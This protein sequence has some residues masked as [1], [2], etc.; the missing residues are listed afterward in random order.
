MRVVPLG[1][2]IAVKRLDAEETTAGGIV[3][4]DAEGCFYTRLRP[5]G[6]ATHRRADPFQKF[7]HARRLRSRVSPPLLARKSRSTVGARLNCRVGS[8]DD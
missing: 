2:K 8:A 3:L 1:D 5:H 4:P 6:K 7:S